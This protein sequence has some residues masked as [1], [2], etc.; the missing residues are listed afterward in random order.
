MKMKSMQP[1]RRLQKYPNW[2]LFL[3]GIVSV[4][5]PSQ[6]GLSDKPSQQWT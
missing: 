3:R 6:E 5:T 1:T 4:H 2:L